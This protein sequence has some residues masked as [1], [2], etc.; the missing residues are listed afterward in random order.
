[1]FP[2]WVWDLESHSLSLPQLLVLSWEFIPRCLGMLLQFALQ[3]GGRT[4]QWQGDYLGYRVVS[5]LQGS[6]KAQETQG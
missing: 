4:P 2:R 1:M 3:E 5:R 6:G